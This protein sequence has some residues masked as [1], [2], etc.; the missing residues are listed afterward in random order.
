MVGVNCHQRRTG[1]NTDFKM[2]KGEENSSV[3]VMPF[4]LHR[5][6]ADWVSHTTVNV[7]QQ[8]HTGPIGV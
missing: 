8:H 6:V 1:T 3:Q 4:E 5:G 7:L 2:L